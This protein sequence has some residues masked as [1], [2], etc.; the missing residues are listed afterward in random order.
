[1]RI[2]H[3]NSKFKKN[4]LKIRKL[5]LKAETPMTMYRL[6]KKQNLDYNSPTAYIVYNVYNILYKYILHIYI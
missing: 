6:T 3:I 4:V 1:M 2:L 5:L